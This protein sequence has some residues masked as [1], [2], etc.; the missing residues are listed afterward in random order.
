MKPTKLVTAAALALAFSGSAMA[1][2]V[3]FET[4]DTSAG[5]VQLLDPYPGGSLLLTWDQVWVDNYA[6]VT[7]TL[8]GLFPGYESSTGLTGNYAFAAYDLDFNPGLTGGFSSV[9]AFNFESANLVAAYDLGTSIVLNVDG[10]T[11]GN[12]IAAFSQQVILDPL[13]TGTGFTAF[14]FTNINEVR[15][16]VAGVIDPVSGLLNPTIDPLDAE[17]GMDNLVITSVTPVPEAST[18]GMMIAGLGL[19]GVMVRS[20]RRSM[21]V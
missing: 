4:I 19:V 21:P 6:T 9:D 11:T 1:V 2:T 18:V 10:F 13:N 14:N 15:F 17:F 5:F 16:T 20:R 7:T 8:P 3:D 12:A